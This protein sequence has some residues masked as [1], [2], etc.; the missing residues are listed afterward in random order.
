MP[1]AASIY[2]CEQEWKG[3]KQNQIQDYRNH[4]LQLIS[5]AMWSEVFKSGPFRQVHR[6]EF[7]TTNSWTYIRPWG[8]WGG[9][10]TCGAVINYS[11]V[12]T[13]N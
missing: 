1:N 5:V 7:D 2:Y 11:K 10:E 4:L 12:T 3:E 9:P 6:I 8:G 13:W